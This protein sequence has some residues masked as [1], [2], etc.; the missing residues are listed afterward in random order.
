MP[1]VKTPKDLDDEVYKA[2]VRLRARGEIVKL[3]DVLT[4]IRL[5]APRSVRGRD[6]AEALQRLKRRKLVKY[7]GKRN[8]KTSRVRKVWAWVLYSEKAR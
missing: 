6:V 8:P 4:E 1:A 3:D 5:V 2:V 7:L